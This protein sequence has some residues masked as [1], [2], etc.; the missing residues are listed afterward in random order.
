MPLL[1]LPLPLFLLPVLLPVLPRGSDEGEARMRNGVGLSA[2]TAGAGTTT[3][4]ALDAAPKVPVALTS[5]S[6]RPDE[7][8][9]GIHEEQL[10]APDPA[11]LC[12]DARRRGVWG[13]KRT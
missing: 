10:D 2:P 11:D 4:S 1:P 6:A 12:E 8:D 3:P 13:G 7:D 5:E 9:E